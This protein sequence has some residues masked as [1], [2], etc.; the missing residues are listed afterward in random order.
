M[1]VILLFIH[2]FFTSTI[3]TTNAATTTQN[4]IRYCSPNPGLDLTQC[5]KRIAFCRKSGIDMV[6]VGTGCT[7]EIGKSG[8]IE[9]SQDGG[10]QC[11]KDRTSYCDFTCEE[12]CTNRPF[13]MWSGSFCKFQD[14]STP[15]PVVGSCGK[16]ACIPGST[17]AC[18]T[19]P[20]VTRGVGACKDGIQTCFNAGWSPICVGQILPVNN[21]PC[22]LV[23][24]LDCDGAV[25]DGSC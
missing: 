16:V 15:I 12:Q 5:N 23:N 17:R 9:R 19:G 3:T 21:P 14:G 18:Y 2:Y 8:R 4:L 7:H 11:G 22:S 10:C 13:C 24:D 6:W 20:T 25:D 1:W